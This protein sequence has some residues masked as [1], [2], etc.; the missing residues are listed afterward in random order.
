MLSQCGEYLAVSDPDL[1]LQA[2]ARARAG[3]PNADGS[4]WTFKI[5]R[6]VKFHDGRTLTAH[7]VAATM[8]RLAD[9]ANGSIALSAFAGALSKGGTR[10]LDERHGR[11]PA[12]CAER[13]LPL[14]RVVRQ[15][16]TPSSC[17]RIMPAASSATST[18]PA[19]SGSS[20]TLPKARASFV[21]NESTG[22]RRRCPN[23]RAVQLLRQHPGAGARH[24]G[25][26]ARRAA[27]RAGA[28]QPS[29]CSPI[30]A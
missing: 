6:G 27:A 30:R 20:A 14:P 26:T 24:A 1:H 12:R 25:R 10:A 7:D 5:R 19:R 15:L 18:A 9:P 8:N 28:G 13:Q 17:P 21:R 4:V 2:A 11:V 3:S 29:A 22:A 16:T 23:A